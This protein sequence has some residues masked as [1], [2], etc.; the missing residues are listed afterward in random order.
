LTVIIVVVVF[1][2]ISLDSKAIH[3]RCAGI[4]I[5]VGK[6]LPLHKLVEFPGFF[7]EVVLIKIIPPDLGLCLGLRVVPDHHAFGALRAARI[8][9]IVVVIGG[10]F[11]GTTG[12][13]QESKQP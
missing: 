1:D 9:P 8:N 11:V 3:L 6:Y 4:G 10:L 5:G 13:H 7:P 12:C 2:V